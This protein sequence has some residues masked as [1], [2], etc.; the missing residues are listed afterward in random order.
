MDIGFDGGF[1]AIKAVSGD[2][3][4]QFPSVV[5]RPAQALF[6]FNPGQSIIIDTAF[7]HYLIGADAVRQGQGARK[8]TA[9]WVHSDAWLAMFYA[10][11][12]E[13]TS[14]TQA[15]LNV[16]AG[17]PLSDFARHKTALRDRLLGTHT[18]TRQG[19]RGQTF[20]IESVRVVPQAWGAVLSM[21]L[22]A[23]GRVVRP[24][25]ATARLAVIDI[26]GH[27]VNYLAV[28]GL[29][30]VP[31]ETR[32]TERG[33]WTVMRAV[34]DFF[35]AEHP[36]LSR[37]RDHQVM[38]AIREGQVYDAGQQ[39]DLGPVVNPLLDDIGQEIVDTAAQYW[40]GGAATFQQVIVCGGGAHLWGRR[41]QRAFR[42]TTVLD[43][44]QFANAQ[45]FHCFAAHLA[46]KGQR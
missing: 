12:T 30:D 46:A 13:L 44:P 8:E 10:A 4:V 1:H 32:S 5:S 27:T 20:R 6:S 35:D 39:I 21:L 26:G 41:V 16:V 3:R 28:D 37:L 9:D 42:H 25:L 36:G 45:G 19:R 31:S 38:Q 23:R 18:L 14:A 40:G 29:S 43:E 22:D 24:E 11:C 7:G 15:A 33:A 34:R 17:L 2:R